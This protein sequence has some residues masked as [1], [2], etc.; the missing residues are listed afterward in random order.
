MRLFS[1]NASTF[2]FELIYVYSFNYRLFFWMGLKEVIWCRKPLH[3]WNNKVGLSKYLNPLRV[4]VNTEWVICYGI[5]SY[6]HLWQQE[7]NQLPCPGLPLWRLTQ[8]LGCF[9]FW[10]ETGSLGPPCCSPSPVYSPRP[11]FSLTS[12]REPSHSS[13]FQLGGGCLLAPYKMAFSFFLCA[14]C[15]FSCFRAPRSP[16]GTLPYWG[17]T[18]NRRSSLQFFSFLSQYA[19]ALPFAHSNVD[20]WLWIQYLQ[21]IGSFRGLRW[22]WD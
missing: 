19:L 9:P 11:L 22:C 7:S 17:W 6:C 15:Y 5:T 12:T 3:F 8:Q 20:F 1:L 18:S 21:R 10:P 2:A 13:D 4:F 14:P 16:S